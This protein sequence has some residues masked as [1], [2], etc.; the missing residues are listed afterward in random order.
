M[1]YSDVKTIVIS[2][3]EKPLTGKHKTGLN[4]AAC[5]Y[6]T[7]I[8]KNMDY[9]ANGSEAQLNKF[10]RSWKGCYGQ[11]VNAHKEG[12]EVAD[13]YRSI[14]NGKCMRLKDPSVEDLDEVM[15]NIVENDQYK[16]E[17]YNVT[18]FTD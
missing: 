10:K 3:E 17:R 5:V 15:N 8:P 9:K 11:F 1:T 16:C 12:D 14:N 13:F 18:K 2:V 6:A 7:R 4:C